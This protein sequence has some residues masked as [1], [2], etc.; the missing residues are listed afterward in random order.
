MGGRES[1]LDRL[2]QWAV[3]SHPQTGHINGRQ[4][5]IPRQV[6]EVILP[7]KAAFLFPTWFCGLS[8][9]N[10]HER[11]VPRQVAAVILPEQAAF[12]PGSVG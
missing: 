4:R 1:C 10:E 12:V 11:V 8:Y 2:H 3:E 6:M 5:V 7:E 9:I